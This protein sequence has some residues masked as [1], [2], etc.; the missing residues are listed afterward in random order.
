MKS[1]GINLT[2][3]KAGWLLLCLVGL[4][5]V[6]DKNVCPPAWATEI[7]WNNGAGGSFS[8]TTNWL[9]QQVPGTSDDAVFNLGSVGG[10]TVTLGQDYVNDQLIVRTDKTVLD[11]G[12]H[13]YTL[14]NTGSGSATSSVV[15]GQNASDNAS[16]TLSNGTLSSVYAKIASPGSGAPQ[17][18]IV[19]DGAYWSNTQGMDIG[20]SGG[21]TLTVQNGGQ[22][23][24]GGTLKLWAAGIVNLNGGAIEAGSLVTTAI[25]SFYWTTGRLKITDNQLEVDDSFGP[26]GNSLTIDTGKILQVPNPSIKSGSLMSGRINITNG[27]AVSS[28]HGIIGDA[29]NS[30]GTVTMSGLN[31]S[32]AITDKFEI[33]ATGRGT[34]LI[35][36]GAVASAAKVMVGEF[37]GSNGSVTIG[38]SASTLNALDSMYVGGGTSSGGTGTGVSTGETV[39]VTSTLK[40]WGSGTINLNGGTIS[41]RTFQAVSGS[42]FNFRNGTLRVDGGSF[43]PSTST[44]TLDG[45]TASDLPVLELV[46]GATLTLSGFMI[47]GL[48]RKGALSVTGGSLTAGMLRVGDHA[49]AQ[50]TATVTGSNSNV[51]M[52]NLHV[53]IS[54]S[55]ALNISSGGIVNATI[56]STVGTYA[57][58]TGTATVSGSGSLLN[59][60][61]EIYV[62]GGSVAAGGTGT[63]NVQNG[64]KVSVT[65]TLKLWGNGTVN[66][67]G[68]T[69]ETGS[70][71][72]T[73]IGDSH[74]TTG[75]LS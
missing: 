28:L 62:G 21:G 69:I 73:E 60:T 74:W 13:S 67:D 7:A 35:D 56:D 14:Q 54:G 42:T 38:A 10:Y 71:V 37:A 8:Q 39:N 44:V 25:P 36:G 64:G 15:V 43:V 26:F 11:L 9:P 53:G 17:G 70:L 3:C 40:I 32:W 50:G 33:G 6:A 22:V 48:D 23:S 2:V 16:L 20:Q 66:L 18:A 46:G 24:V 57:G 49:G 65:G 1:R 45:A 4:A 59:T 29:V 19:V 61:G 55:G 52:A 75:T 41:T 51:Q 72:V 5:L 31:S 34:L 12:G 68:G 47:V 63:V 58:G 30:T 27:G